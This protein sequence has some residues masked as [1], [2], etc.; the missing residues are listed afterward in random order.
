LGRAAVRLAVI[1]PATAVVLLLLSVLVDTAATQ[2]AGKMPRVGYL[3]PF[4]D[5]D[6]VGRRV[7]EAFRQGL[8]E[9]GYAEGQNIAIE[10]RSAEGKDERLPALAADLVRSKVDVIVATSGAATRAV[11]QTIRTIP[12]VMSQ[13][14]DPV[15]SGLVANLARPGGNVTG[16]TI[17]SPDLVAKR[18]ELLKELVPKV[19]RVGLLRNPDNPASAAM[20]QEAEAAAR[21]LGV[22]LQTLEA[23]N[24]QEIEVAFAA[25][26]KERAG[27]LLML[28]DAI[29]T[30]QRRQIAELA[31]KGRLPSLGPSQYPAAGGLMAYGPNI[32]DLERRAASF[33]DRILKGAKPGDLPVEQPTKFDLVI[34]LRTAKA[35]GLS[36][37][38]SLSQRADQL[39]D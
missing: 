30:T 15:G 4:P 21:A 16:L 33:V 38:S 7:L 22:R 37:P 3:T 6:P 17:M 11:Q 10:S 5:S 24:P 35:I 31:A 28:T 23:R 39:I 14:N 2:P 8:R 25:M 29:F 18:L 36:I 19:S 1:R 12:I 13:A 34:N 20:L 26:L 32:F 9:L 27:A